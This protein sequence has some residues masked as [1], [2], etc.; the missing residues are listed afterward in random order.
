[1]HLGIVDEEAFSGFVAERNIL[2]DGEVSHY[3]CLL[4]N[5]RD[6]AVNYC[7]IGIVE[8]YA[9]AVKVYFAFIFRVNSVKDVQDCGFSCA[10]FAEQG[11]NLAFFNRERYILQNVSTG[12]MFVDVEKFDCFRHFLSS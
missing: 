6:F 11:G 8:T 5:F 4:M 12:K 1:M 7:F 10:V 3:Q 2:P 9:F